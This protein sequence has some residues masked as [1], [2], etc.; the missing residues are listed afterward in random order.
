VRLEPGE[1]PAPLIR[2][3]QHAARDLKAAHPDL[4]AVFP[5]QRLLEAGS[6]A[7][8]EPAAGVVVR[9]LIR[10]RP[11]TAAALEREFLRLLA[12][13]RVSGDEARRA[14]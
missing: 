6:N 5:A 11:G 8:G 14:A 13:R 10:T 2:S 1:D 9:T 4:L 7:P 12:L 3:L